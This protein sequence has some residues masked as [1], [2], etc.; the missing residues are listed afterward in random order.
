MGRGRG[1]G[2][3][4]EKRTS[5]SEPGSRSA[6]LFRRIDDAYERDPRF[7]P[8]E[9]LAHRWQSIVGA[10]AEAERA[11]KGE[12]QQHGTWKEEG[13]FEGKGGGSGGSGHGA[14]IGAA[15]KEDSTTSR[16]TRRLC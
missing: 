8:F 4:R 1:R 6:R 2:R 3:G 13:R 16:R 5:A 14:G 9:R 7:G 15:A 10:G 11:G 12:E